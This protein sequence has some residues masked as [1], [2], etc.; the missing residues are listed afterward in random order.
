M[1]GIVQ[2]FRRAAA[3][4]AAYYTVTLA[5]PVANGAGGRAFTEHALVVAIVPAAMILMVAG[6]TALG[7]MARDRA[8]GTRS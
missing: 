4:L 5:M 1:T 2:A 7:R 6:V 8:R 3:P